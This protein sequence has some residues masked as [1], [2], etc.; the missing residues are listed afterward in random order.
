MGGIDRVLRA[1]GLVNARDLGGLRRTDGTTTPR[2]VFSRSED[3]DRLTPAGWEQV[4]AAGI[5]T[6]VDLRQAGER[7]ADTGT[8]PD[9]VRTVHVDLDGLEDQDFW[10]HYWPT[11]LMGTA[12]Y[13]LP[14]LAAMPERAGAALSAIVLAPPGGV[15]F[16]CVSGRDRTGMVALLLLAAARVHPDAVV[17]DYLETVRLA[18]ERARATGRPDEEAD[19]EALCRSHGTTTEGAFRAAL[20]GLDLADVLTRSSLDP[21]AREALYSWRGS[22]GSPTGS[23]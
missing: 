11:G 14:H 1:E 16:H 17:E 13:Y 21:A 22:L 19:L 6:V 10:Q 2:G 23:P 4:R 15:L 3:V 12:L 18:P 5:R 8:R 7:A 9:W 20:T